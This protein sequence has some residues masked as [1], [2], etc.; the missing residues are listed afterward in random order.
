MVRRWCKNGLDLLTEEKNHLPSHDD[1]H[2]WGL[3]EV[4]ENT[5]DVMLVNRHGSKRYQIDVASWE[6]DGDYCPS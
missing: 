3:L 4:G 5:I 1:C 6:S 2:N